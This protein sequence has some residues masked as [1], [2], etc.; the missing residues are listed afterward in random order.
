MELK[1]YDYQIPAKIDMNFEE[2]KAWIT[3]K[4]E[5]YSAMVYTDEQ[6]KQAT[7]DRADLNRLKKAMNDERIRRQKEY[8]KP[9]DDLKK[10][11]DELIGIIDKPVSLIDSRVKAFEENEKAE[12]RAKI[13]EY[14]DKVNPYEWLSLETIFD[15]SWLNKTVKSKQIA[16]EL[17][18]LFNAISQ[19]LDTLAEMPEFAFEATEVYKNTLDINK[20]ISEG[21]KL[22]EMAKRKAEYEARAK[23]RAEQ[24]TANI[25][26]AMTDLPKATP[27]EEEPPEILPQAETLPQTEWIGFEAL[28]TPA[29]AKELA[30]F[31]KARNIKYRKPTK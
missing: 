30:G 20:A 5:L 12:K 28:L 19:N 22:A 23:E 9:F 27:T 13:A 8:M 7:K 29:Q 25:Q 31:F 2:V 21:K 4:A 11:I 6:I 14:F 10:Q 24:Q 3:E 17:E 15:K 16:V 26:E 1:I 18:F